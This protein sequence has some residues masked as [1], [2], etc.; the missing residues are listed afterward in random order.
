MVIL[1]HGLFV[2]FL[3]ALCG[4]FCT[5][6]VARGQTDLALDQ[7]PSVASLVTSPG[8]CVLQDEQQRCETQVAFLWE[9]PEKDN[10][11][12]WEEGQSQPLRCWQQSW[13]GTW[14]VQLTATDSK[15]YILRTEKQLEISRTT[16]RVIGALEQRIRAR[17]RSGF[18]RVF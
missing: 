8:V 16:I 7:Q 17:R 3:F 12:L 13:S 1:R 5:I 9:V 15:T 6:N 14:Q 11:C 10:Y 4:F 18:W 2:P